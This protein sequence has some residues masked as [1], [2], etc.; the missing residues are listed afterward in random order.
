MVVLLA[1]KYKAVQA[2]AGS[3]LL[4]STLALAVTV[5]AILWLKVDAASE[6]PTNSMGDETHA[7][8]RSAF[9]LPTLLS[10]TAGAVDVISFLGFGGLFT[11]HITGNLVILAAHYITGRFGEIAPLLSVPVF[12]LVLGVITAVFV[13]RPIPFTRRALLVLQAVLLAC[14][15]GF[16]VGFGPF[17]DPNS[18]MA[19]F[20]GMLGVAAMATQNAVVRVALPGHPTTAVMSP[21]F[22]QLAVDLAMLARGLPQPTNASKIR[23]RADVTILAVL[24]FVV[25]VV[26]G[27]I[28]EIHFGLWSLIFPSLLAVA[29][30]PLSKSWTASL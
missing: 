10:M 19:V 27:A 30:I 1:T 12:V 28:L 20:V 5:P 7:Y 29:A 2:E 21:N 18:R 22:A 9:L 15:L 25:G 8:R 13:R 26:A 17:A 6:W 23:F 3:M 14:F 4:V 16:G 24:G 11:A